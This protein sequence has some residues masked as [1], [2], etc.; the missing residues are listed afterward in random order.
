M[1]QKLTRIL[2]QKKSR[3]KGFGGNSTN[4]LLKLIGSGVFK[5]ASDLVILM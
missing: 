4:D 3:E 2:H 5:E 1:Y